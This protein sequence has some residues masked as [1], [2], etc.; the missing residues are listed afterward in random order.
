MRPREAIHD[1]RVL[2]S[3]NREMVVRD[4]TT[5]QSEKDLIGILQHCRESSTSLTPSKIQAF[6]TRFANLEPPRTHSEQSTSE[7]QTESLRHWLK[8]R[9]QG[10]TGSWPLTGQFWMF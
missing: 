5:Q 3:K 9:L 1:S 8:S 6:A 7:F 2:E 10:S 4:Q